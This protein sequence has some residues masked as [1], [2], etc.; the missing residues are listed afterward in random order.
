MDELLLNETLVAD[1]LDVL[2]KHN[3]VDR[4]SLRNHEIRR[5]YRELRFKGVSCK[6][7]RETVASEFSLT[8]KSIE[9]IIYSK[10][11]DYGK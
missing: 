1:I 9:Q 2:V 7:S 8:E 10:K 5:R 11:I 4:H 6:K 3:V